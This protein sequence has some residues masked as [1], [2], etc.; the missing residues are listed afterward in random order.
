MFRTAAIG[1]RYTGAMATS[2]PLLTPE[3]QRQAVELGRK[4]LTP[5]ENA[6]GVLLYPPLREDD[7]EFRALGFTR[8]PLILGIELADAPL[9]AVLSE[10]P[11]AAWREQFGEL[12]QVAEA[13]ARAKNGAFLL[14]ALEYAAVRYGDEEMGLAVVRATPKMKIY[15]QFSV[16]LR[17]VITPAAFDAA[18]IELCRG[19]MARLGMLIWSLLE[20]HSAW[21]EKLS[22]LVLAEVRAATPLPRHM[23]W[24]WR[25][26]G[27]ALHM[28]P[29]FV[30]EALSVMRAVTPATA[31]TKRLA[32]KLK[33]RLA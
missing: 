30:A 27:L 15:F 33:E 18:L 3:Q 28:H 9:A 10:W 31:Q 20:I 32:K 16:F 24:E 2:K 4:Y 26:N 23:V 19:G 7:A 5:Q 14:Y 17:E 8:F 13:A 21:S 11:A 25:G 6:F 29:N 22:E 1:L 12:S